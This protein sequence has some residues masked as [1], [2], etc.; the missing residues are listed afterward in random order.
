MSSIRIDYLHKNNFSAELQRRLEVHGAKQRLAEQTGI[1]PAVIS[2]Y[3]SGVNEPTVGNLTLIARALGVSLDELVFGEQPP[4]LQLPL[5]I[6]AVS[7]VQTKLQSL[8]LQL[9]PDD[10]AEIVGRLYAKALKD[11]S[12]NSIQENVVDFVALVAKKH[13]ATE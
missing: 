8:G 3:V 10:T 12:A 7:A 9:S 5:L 13:A 11:K 1:N 2:R 4:P 6:R